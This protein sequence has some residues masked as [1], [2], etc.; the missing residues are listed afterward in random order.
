MIKED[1]KLYTV[2]G[3]LTSLDFKEAKTK[4]G[5][6]PYA[7][8]KLVT[9]ETAGK[10]S[11]TI[12]IL[13]FY[14]DG[15]KYLKEQKVGHKVKLLGRFGTF[16]AKDGKTKRTFS[17]MFGGDLKQALEEKKSKELTKTVR[18]V[19]QYLED[20]EFTGTKDSMKAR[21]YLIANGLGKEGELPQE[22]GT[23]EFFRKR[24][25]HGGT[26]F[27]DAAS[28][29]ALS[30]VDP[31][32][33]SKK[34]LSIKDTN[35]ASVYHVAAY[36][37][38]LDQIPEDE[39]DQ[40]ALLEPDVDGY[41]VYHAAALKD[42]IDKLPKKLL[43]ERSLCIK[44]REGLT[45]AHTCAARG[46][47]NHIPKKELTEKVLLRRD[48]NDNT[49]MHV[50]AAAGKLH[51]VPKHLLTEKT[52][53]VFGKSGPKKSPLE[54]IP[55]DQVSQ[56]LKLIPLDILKKLS[57]YEILDKNFKAKLLVTIASKSKE[58][59]KS[60]ERNTEGVV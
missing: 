34:N 11:I 43:N 15:I 24:H 42:S 10:K 50:A 5:L 57:D 1:K 29:N 59:R 12:P 20:S 53:L 22:W 40:Q 13:T 45:P 18:S 16:T 37:G 36:F 39:F 4:T 47:L 41:S 32:F 46:T 56:T 25:E 55:K 44:D 9:P 35:D 52:L 31:N 23:E 30:L 17:A 27:H 54:L 48:K 28:L 21:L 51:K 7:V 3:T 19:G 33:L 14:P 60:R 2:S 58:G 38:C 6:K 26:A 49:A 8:G